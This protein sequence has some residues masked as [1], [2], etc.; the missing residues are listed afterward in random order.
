MAKSMRAGGSNNSASKTSSA[1]SE[2]SGTSQS[3]LPNSLIQ[4][5]M[6]TAVVQSGHEDSILELAA[7][8]LAETDTQQETKPERRQQTAPLPEI[9]PDHINTN[10]YADFE[11]GVA[12]VKGEDDE[13]A[14][15]PND[16]AQGS[17]GD[18]YLMAAMVAVARATPEAI[19]E[20]IK[21][22]EDGT[23]DVSLH[24]RD[25]WYEGPKPKTHTVD[26]RLPEKFEGTP[27]YAKLGDQTPESQEMWPALLEKALA[28]EKG[29]FEDIRGSKIA[30]G[31][32][33]F[34]GA[35]ELLTG[36]GDT[37]MQVSDMDED[38]VLLKIQKAL[39]D[40]KPVVTGVHN[41]KDEPERANEARKYNV[42]GNHAYAPE[43]V[44]IENRTISLTNPWGKKHVE[45]IPVAEFMKY[46]SRIRI[47]D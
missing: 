32:F 47:G 30:R 27:L 31:N 1:K 18:C 15:A 21:D 43:S 34:A 38:E 20:L 45:S 11:K 12:F 24:I 33:K 35:L 41:M 2:K 3:G 42:Y 40:K 5:I 17:L 13:H 14:I 29:G 23:F 44:D 8:D 10:Q 19:D 36:K 6:E 9:R 22:N 25:N 4:S 39:A 46:Y 7:T 37:S 28:Q 16:V 26:T